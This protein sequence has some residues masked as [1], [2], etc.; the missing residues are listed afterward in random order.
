MKEDNMPI[1]YYLDEKISSV[2]TEVA[3][4][5]TYTE[6]EGFRSHETAFIVAAKRKTNHDEES[7]ATSGP[8]VVVR[9]I[10]AAE[11]IF[12]PSFQF[13]VYVDA[14]RWDEASDVQRQ[15]MVH[16]AL[17]CIKVELKPNGVKYSTCRPDVEANQS[18]ILRFGAWDEPLRLLRENL[19]K[20][21]KK[22]KSALPADTPE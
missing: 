8:P 7:V 17:G 9:K 16:K 5:E 18:N 22:A 20:A 1:E 13:K 21:Q 15:A 3:Q 2:V 6:F 11:A 10:A 4:N 14:H 12:L 19:A